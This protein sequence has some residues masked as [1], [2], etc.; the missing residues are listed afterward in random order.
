MRRIRRKRTKIDTL[1]PRR[2]NVVI[3]NRCKK[4]PVETEPNEAL[5][6][7]PWGIV[8]APPAGSGLSE[9]RYCQR[10]TLVLFRAIQTLVAAADAPEPPK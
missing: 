7:A 8:I 4:D 5:K 6:A 1:R 2:L 9:L 10:C 3:C